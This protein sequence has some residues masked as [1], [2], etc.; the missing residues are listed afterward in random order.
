MKEII[1]K[2]LVKATGL[3][4]EEV[5]NLLE[6]PSNEALG[7]Y[8]F[9]CF[10]LSKKLKKSPAD[11]AKD[12]VGKISSKDFKGIESVG[13]YIN[14]FAKRGELVKKI[15]DDVLKLKD[16]Y[17]KNQEDRGK[18]VMIEFPS[19]NTNKPLHLG[20]IRNMALG[21]SLSRIKEFCANKV[22]RANLNNDRGVHISKSM[23]AYKLWGQPK[24]DTP[25][26]SG[27]K[28]DHFIG[29]YYVMFGN[30]AKVNPKL[31]DE[32]QDMLRAWEKGDK[33]V[34]RLWILMNGWAL[35]GFRKTYGTFGI[36]HDKEYFE[37]EIYKEGKDLI[38]KGLEEGKFIKKDGAIIFDLSEE[39]LG[40]K[41]LIRSDGTSVY[42]TQD[43]A[44]AKMKYDEFGLD[45]S[46]YV[47]G[48]EQD[49]HFRVL[50][51]LVKT[52][53]IKSLNHLSYGMVNLP[54]GRMKSREGTVVDA[55]DLIDE[56]KGLVKKE[57]LLRF[58]DI[59][60]ADVEKRSLV[61]ALASIKYFILRVGASRNM[62]Y[63]PRE[64]ISF[65]GNTGPYLLYSYARACS[66]LRKAK[67]LKK[68]GDLVVDGVGD[69]EYSLIKKLG[70][71]G[72]VILQ[73]REKLDPSIIAN[74]AYDLA[75]AFSEF[76]QASQVLGSDEE[77]YRLKLVEAFTHVMK[78]A[79]YLLG[80]E[81][82]SEM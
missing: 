59:K 51:N 38:L 27:L 1:I 66:I 16:D 10:I 44:L 6:V 72:S 19:P 46:M 20:H 18:K 14:F 8:A 65:E 67:E 52:L 40:E 57:I 68:G 79:L 12:L 48:N 2:S 75:K 31:E 21:E 62:L 41:V 42:I 33:E 74:Y 61:I 49:Y 76:Y 56:V 81:A 71:F 11:I 25:E 4:K 55:D 28:S 26:K 58:P 70:M 5:E 32:A 24:G 47:V 64:S 43:V 63:N 35:E 45:E 60:G 15:L 50:Q 73:A 54:D 17:G 29:K 77:N 13:P 39:G 82:I 69:S 53:G 3:T 7:D 9:P 37:S 23:L 78:N 36:K 30:E 34:M 22:I 80:I